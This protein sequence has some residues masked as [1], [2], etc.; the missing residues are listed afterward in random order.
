MILP[1]IRP[2]RVENPILWQ[3]LTHQH[4][5]APTAQQREFLLALVLATALVGGALLLLPNNRTL[6]YIVTQYGLVALWAFTATVMIRAVV[7]GANVISREHV[8]RTWDALVL[9]GVS[10]RR[11]MI[12]KWLAAVR[13]V[14]GWGVALACLRMVFVPIFFFSTTQ[15]YAYYTWRRMGSYQNQYDDVV[16]TIGFSPGITFTAVIVALLMPFIEIAACA[17]LGVAASGITQRGASAAVLAGIVRFVPTILTLHS[18]F[19]RY[20]SSAPYWRWLRMPTFSLADA[21]TGLMMRLSMPEISWTRSTYGWAFSN[22]G[23]PLLL[24][25]TFTALALVVTLLMARRQGALPH[26]KALKLLSQ[27]S[28]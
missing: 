2:P 4:R 23:A 13:R 1:A 27:S 14:W 21:G 25:F 28:A 17:A 6:G 11:I 5:A 22:L 8:G 7:A 9:T 18:G 20:E 24:L 10:A 15:S 26:P 12:G 19:V 16:Y 3:E